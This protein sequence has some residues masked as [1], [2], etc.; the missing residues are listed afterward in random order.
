MKRP[1]ITFQTSVTISAE[2]RD[3]WNVLKDVKHWPAWTPTIR[4]VVALDNEALMT[5]RRYR[6]KQPGIATAVWKATEVDPKKG[7]TWETRTIGLRLTAS[8][9]L[10]G[11]RPTV[12]TLVF[13]LEGPLA[14]FVA[15]LA[16]KKIENY[17]ELEAESL[18]PLLLQA[19]CEYVVPAV[20]I[21]RGGPACGSEQT[22]AAGPR[23][24]GF[25]K[26]TYRQ[27]STP[28]GPWAA[29]H[30]ARAW[31]ASAVQKAIERSIVLAWEDE[32]GSLAP[33]ALP[34]S[35]PARQ[36]RGPQRRY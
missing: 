19:A 27:I 30:A 2:R 35:L 1:S 5:G 23:T 11:I 29:T 25:V 9:N 10:E 17:L 15:A 4:S 14:R 24:L 33:D 20:L 21:I 3:V 36:S 18:R 12:V 32:G 16:R 8:H 22:G 31:R 7:F 34:F 26:I 6:V 13:A 28:T